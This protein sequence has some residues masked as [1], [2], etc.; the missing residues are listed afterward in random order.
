MLD[1]VVRSKLEIAQIHEVLRIAVHNPEVDAKEL[2]RK[3]AYDIHDGKRYIIPELVQAIL[4]IGPLAKDGVGSFWHYGNGVWINSG[5]GEINRR[6]QWILGSRYASRHER[7]VISPLRTKTPLIEGLGSKNYLNVPNGMLN[8]KTEELVPHDPKYRSTYQLTMKWN[9]GATCPQVDAWIEETFDPEIHNLL[10][11]IIGVTLFPGMGPQTGIFLLG[12]GGNGKSTFL[13]LCQACLPRSAY[14]S[15]DP[16]QLNDDKF[17]GYDLFGK[18]ANIVGDLSSLT[19][20][21]TEMFKKLTGG[22]EI[23]GER[24]HFDAMKF[25]SD[26]T[27]LFA[28]NKM[29]ESPDKSYGWARRV[30]IV[31]MTRVITGKYDPTLEERLHSELEGVLVKAVRA[32]RDVMEVGHFDEPSS[33]KFVREK[34]LQKADSTVFFITAAIKF[35][36]SFESPVANSEIVARYQAFCKS[37]KLKMESPTILFRSLK[38]LGEPHLQSEK[39]TKGASGKRERGFTGL[40]ITSED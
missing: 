24:K 18:T 19:L 33:S 10:W 11:Q 3:I 9:P 25:R 6:V 31:P 16:Q 27:Q 37:R 29:P 12:G 32:L 40:S 7:E 38:E 39:W 17:A 30:L 1:P 15:V 23:R 21:G 13:R 8:W 35:S 22:D 2:A 20:K 5:L 4:M 34:Y 14:C 26:A 28:G 36:D